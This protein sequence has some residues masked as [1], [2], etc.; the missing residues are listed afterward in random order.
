MLVISAV[1][2]EMRGTE[3]VTVVG[4]PTV[5]IDDKSLVEIFFFWTDKTV[6]GNSELKKANY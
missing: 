5:E 1:A 3:V 2:T 6:V 4:K